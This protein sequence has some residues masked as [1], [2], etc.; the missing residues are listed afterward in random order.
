MYTSKIWA[1]ILPTVLG[2]SVLVLML[3]KMFNDVV[4]DGQCLRKERYEICIEHPSCMLDSFELLDYTE[5][6]CDERP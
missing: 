3:S 4:D 2:I 1:I 5:A 6:D